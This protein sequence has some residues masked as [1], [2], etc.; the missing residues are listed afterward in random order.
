VSADPPIC[1]KH[2]GAYK[3]PP[4]LGSR[5][6]LS[7]AASTMPSSTR[8]FAPYPSSKP[9]PATNSR[10]SHP[11]S[12][13]ATTTNQQFWSAP[14]NTTTHT[15]GF[16]SQFTY[17]T[18]WETCP[19]DLQTSWFAPGAQSGSPCSDDSAVTTPV[20]AV[21]QLP[22][23]PLIRG[24]D[25]GVPGLG[26]HGLFLTFPPFDIFQSNNGQ[27]AVPASYS[28][29]IANMAQ[30]KLPTDYHQPQL[31]SLVDSYSFHH[32]TPAKLETKRDCSFA[33]TSPQFISPFSDSAVTSRPQLL[34]LY[35][36]KPVRPIPE[37][38]FTPPEDD[39]LPSS[40]LLYQPV[41]KAV[42]ETCFRASPKPL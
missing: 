3:T 42:R 38:C 11:S 12:L 15:T 19:L 41:S 5:P 14:S 21:S 28:D 27:M 24:V 35:A 36:P 31:P 8:R 1:Y 6:T 30:A 25:Y 32:Q 23:Q 16:E 34:P 9:T 40:S 37:I 17:P 33:K 18:Y 10:H 39:P 22:P 26:E 20:S 2:L 7:L 4:R 29:S 13:F